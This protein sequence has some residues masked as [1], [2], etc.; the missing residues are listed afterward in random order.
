MTPSR[1]YLDLIAD[2]IAQALSPLVRPEYDVLASE[3]EIALG[4][5]STLSVNG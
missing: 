2:R 1:E 3:G 5:G 4:L